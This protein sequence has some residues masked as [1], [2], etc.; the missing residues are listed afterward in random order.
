M[1][2]ALKSYVLPWQ[3]GI[4]EEVFP[5]SMELVQIQKKKKRKVDLICKTRRWKADRWKVNKQLNHEL[6]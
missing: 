1:T 5:C 6:E 3:L 4:E 2:G